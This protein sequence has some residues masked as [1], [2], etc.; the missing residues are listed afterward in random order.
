[1]VTK[2]G[3]SG[4]NFLTGT[5]AADTSGRGASPY[6]GNPESRPKGALR[7]CDR[8]K[9]RLAMTAWCRRTM[10]WRLKSMTGNGSDPMSGSPN[11]GFSL[12]AGRWRGICRKCF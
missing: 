5:S 4:A 12:G 7:C 1:M 3:T 2:I 9:P 6:C 11:D 8:M 10:N